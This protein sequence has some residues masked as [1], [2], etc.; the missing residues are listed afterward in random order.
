LRRVG[1]VLRRKAPARRGTRP[2]RD[3]PADIALLEA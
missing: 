2:G 3:R 1:S